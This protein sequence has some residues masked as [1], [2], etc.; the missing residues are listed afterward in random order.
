MFSWGGR[1]LSC[2]NNFS[3]KMILKRPFLCNTGEDSI[4]FFSGLGKTELQ[5]VL[6]EDRASN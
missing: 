6:L 3:G 1:A 5:G 2:Y 4:L